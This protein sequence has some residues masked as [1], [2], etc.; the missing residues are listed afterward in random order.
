MQLNINGVAEDWPEGTTLAA[1]LEKKGLKA[2]SI[3]VAINLTFI[4]RSRYSGT[5]LKSGDAIE[6]VAPQQGG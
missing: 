2:G 5:M 6:V 3:A 1:L 4:P